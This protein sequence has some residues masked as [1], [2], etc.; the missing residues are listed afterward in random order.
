MLN[1]WNGNQIEI[2]KM[3]E[4]EIKRPKKGHLDMH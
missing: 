2:L 1:E 3:H 4:T